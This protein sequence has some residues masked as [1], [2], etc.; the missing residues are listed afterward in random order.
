MTT[1]HNL[2]C[3]F[4]PIPFCCAADGELP[5]VIWT[6]LHDLLMVP[7]ILCNYNIILIDE[8]PIVNGFCNIRV[9]VLYFG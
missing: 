5:L 3:P 1:F 7:D 9:K 2:A 4:T 8:K 6:G